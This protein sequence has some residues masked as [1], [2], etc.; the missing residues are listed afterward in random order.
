MHQFPEI[1]GFSPNSS[2]VRLRDV[3]FNPFKEVGA[4]S[5]MADPSVIEKMYLV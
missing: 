2:M 3:N 1:T 4:M 5:E